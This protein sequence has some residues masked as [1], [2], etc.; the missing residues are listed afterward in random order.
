MLFHC[1]K[2][3]LKKCINCRRF[4]NRPI[5]L[6]QNVYR[7]FRIDPPNIPFRTVFVDYIGPYHVKYNNKISKVYILCIT[8][9][10]SRA[11]NFKLCTDLTVKHFCVHYSCTL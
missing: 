7:D 8:C 1:C 4:N 6:N 3:H 10:W 11:I 9:L 5:K 2:T